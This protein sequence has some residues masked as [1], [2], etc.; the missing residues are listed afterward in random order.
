MDDSSIIHLFCRAGYITKKCQGIKLEE[1][2]YLSEAEL[3]LEKFAEKS[4]KNKQLVGAAADTIKTQHL[5]SNLAVQDDDDSFNIKP[6][7]PVPSTKESTRAK[8][9]LVFFP[10]NVCSHYNIF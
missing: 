2:E 4:L 9:I 3:F 5:F 8:G 10:G 7:S 6:V 1:R